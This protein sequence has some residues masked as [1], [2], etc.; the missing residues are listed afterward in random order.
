MF[1][2]LFSCFN[3]ANHTYQVDLSSGTVPMPISSKP[4][5]PLDSNIDVQKV[6]FEM[7]DFK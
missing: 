2:K 3:D 5:L 6:N 1:K 4:E 7:D